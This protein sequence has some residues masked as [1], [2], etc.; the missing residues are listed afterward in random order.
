MMRAY[1]WLFPH[2]LLTLLLALV[3]ILLQNNFSAGMAVFGL[4][5]GILIPRLTV[6]WWPDRP[7][8]LHLGQMVGYM[9][10]VLWDILVANVQVAWIVLTKPNSK[11]RPAWIVVPLDLRQPEAITI[12]AGTITLT[13]GTVSADLSDEGHSLL[14]H[15]LHTD[16][17]DSV[18]DEI[19]DRYER[20]LKEIF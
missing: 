4:I 3:W 19:K 17:P 18:R 5:L 14:V 16:D 11:L 2:P 12:L 8:R 6:V 1:R 13:P 7:V 10:V 20:R 9:L 15:V